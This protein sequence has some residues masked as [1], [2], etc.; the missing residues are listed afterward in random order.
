MIC[1]FAFTTLLFTSCSS[2]DDSSTTNEN[3][4]LVKK[5]IETYA[6]DGSVLTTNYTYNGKKLLKVSDDEG[7]YEKYFYTG[8]LITKIEFYDFDDVLEETAELTYNSEGKLVTYL[9]T[10]PLDNLAS[11]EIYVYNTNGTVSFTSYSGTIASQT[12]MSGSGTITVTGGEVAMINY[13]LGGGFTTSHTYTYDTKNSPFKNIT[14]YDKLLFMGVEATGGV[15]HNVLTD[16]TVSGIT[17]ETNSVYTY[18]NMNFPL[19]WVE[20]E[21][22]DA[23]TTITTQYIYF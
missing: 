16:T 5:S 15:L 14:G 22:T 17:T 1:L 10:E 21:G 9:M 23:N 3:D 6:N 11:K 8:D 20:T 18:N 12:V 7:Y 19:T 2:S 4:V 13:D